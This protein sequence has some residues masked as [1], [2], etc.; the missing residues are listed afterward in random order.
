MLLFFPEKI[1]CKLT[2]TSSIIMLYG[3][4]IKLKRNSNFV[5]L[6]LNPCNLMPS[7]GLDKDIWRPEKKKKTSSMPIFEDIRGRTTGVCVRE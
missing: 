5:C 1:I 7:R 6:Y 2:Q 3:V 4:K